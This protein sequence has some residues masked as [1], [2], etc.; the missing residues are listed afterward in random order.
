[1]KKKIIIAIIMMKLIILKKRGKKII[2]ITK[3]KIIIHNYIKLA[4]I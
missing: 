3:L 1:M 2:N 4:Y